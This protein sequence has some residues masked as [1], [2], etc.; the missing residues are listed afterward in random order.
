VEELLVSE[1]VEPVALDLVEE[2]VVSELVKKRVVSDSVEKPV[3]S[4][5]VEKATLSDSVEKPVVSGSVEKA[6]VS[7]SVEKASFSDSLEKPFVSGSVEKPVVSGSVEK[8]V[9]SELVEEPVVL[10]EELVVSESV[11]PVVL[12]LLEKPVVSELVEKPVVSDSVEKPV[13]LDLVEKPV[14]SDSV[15][16]PVVL[17]L[18]EKPAFSDS[19]E[20]PVVSDSVE[21]AAVS[22]SVEKPIVSGSVE[23]PVVSDSVEK[24]AISELAEELVSNLEEEPFVSDSVEKPTTVSV[25][26][27]TVSVEESIVSVEESI[28]S[29]LLEKCNIGVSDQEEPA[30]QIPSVSAVIKSFQEDLTEENKA[31]ELGKSALRNIVDLQNLVQDQTPRAV[32]K[33]SSSDSKCDPVIFSETASDPD[34]GNNRTVTRVEDSSLEEGAE[35]HSFS[36]DEANTSDVNVLIEPNFVPT[37]SY[38]PPTAKEEITNSHSS[39]A[40]EATVI[41]HCSSCPSAQ[42]YHQTTSKTSLEKRDVTDLKESKGHL[43]LTSVVS[44][45]LSELQ[46]NET[47]LTDSEGNVE[48]LTDQGLEDLLQQPEPAQTKT[49]ESFEAVPDLCANNIPHTES[50]K[51]KEK[52]ISSSSVHTIDTTDL[53]NSV[54]S[55][56]I[57]GTSFCDPSAQILEEELTRCDVEVENFTNEVRKSA[58]V[59][60]GPRAG[61]LEKVGKSG[62]DAQ[63][64]SSP[65]T[66]QTQQK[67]GDGT[68]TLT[69]FTCESSLPLC[70]ITETEEE[71]EKKEKAEFDVADLK[72]NTKE[73]QFPIAHTNAEELKEVRQKADS[74]L[75][76]ESDCV[77]LREV[78]IER[79]DLENPANDKCF[80]SD[81][82]GVNEEEFTRN[83]GQKVIHETD[84]GCKLDEVLQELSYLNK[85]IQSEGNEN[86]IGNFCSEPYADS[87]SNRSIDTAGS[88]LKT[89]I[90]EDNQQVSQRSI[91]NSVEEG[92]EE[93]VTFE[94]NLH[95][96][97]QS[98]QN[99]VTGEE[100]KQTSYPRKEVCS[101]T[102]GERKKTVASNKVNR[103][104][105]DTLAGVSNVSEGKTSQSKA[106]NLLLENYINSKGNQTAAESVNMEQ[107]NKKPS[108][109]VEYKG[110]LNM[111]QEKEKFSGQVKYKGRIN[112]EKDRVDCSS[113]TPIRSKD[114]KS[115]KYRRMNSDSVLL[116]EKS[117][118]SL[119]VLL[120]EINDLVRRTSSFECTDLDIRYKPVKDKATRRKDFRK[121]SAVKSHSDKEINIGSLVSTKDAVDDSNVLR[122]VEMYGDG[123]RTELKGNGDNRM[124]RSDAVA[125]G[126]GQMDILPSGSVLGG[127]RR[128]EMEG[129]QAGKPIQ[130]DFSTT[131]ECMVVG[132]SKIKKEIE[133]L[134]QES[135]FI[136][137]ENDNMDSKFL[138]VKDHL[139][140]VQAKPS[141]VLSSEKPN[142]HSKKG[143]KKRFPLRVLRRKTSLTNISLLDVN[144][145][146]TPSDDDREQTAVGGV[147]ST[148]TEGDDS[149]LSV[150][151][152]EREKRILFRTT[153]R[154]SKCR[155]PSEKSHGSN[156]D[157][158]SSLY[159]RRKS[160]QRH[161]S[162]NFSSFVKGHSSNE[163]SFDKGY[164]S[165][166]ESSYEKRSSSS[167]RPR[168]GNRNQ[169]LDSQTDLHP[170][171]R[172]SVMHQS[173]DSHLRDQ[174]SDMHQSIESSHLRNQ[175][176]DLH[177][178]NDS[179]HLRHQRKESRSD[180]HQSMDL[181]HLKQPQRRETSYDREKFVP[182]RSRTTNADKG[183][184]PDRDL[185]GETPPNPRDISHTHSKSSGKG[186]FPPP[187][188]IPTEGLSAFTKLMR[189]DRGMSTMSQKRSNAVRGIVTFL[190]IHQCKVI[191][192][193]S[194]KLQ[195]FL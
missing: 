66:I 22:D 55:A 173:M 31:V 80:L 139:S 83:S 17:D 5:S 86:I 190:L 46:R 193:N 38:H 7:V 186:S 150:S 187:G 92:K 3:V 67:R 94:N 174:S 108:K 153:M 183:T 172:R 131:S 36:T 88:Y 176:L 117:R 122:I 165:K 42:S 155:D 48:D 148:G 81:S 135:P 152:S 24:P 180:K 166:S 161:S 35:K 70:L 30:V 58:V 73:D 87:V 119:G 85:K 129:I 147:R 69:D 164:S 126:V 95:I 146:S 103:E 102:E 49:S 65:S 11:E 16:K 115:E 99:F 144:E 168:L 140:A 167:N 184:A 182:G 41:P 50:V 71:E 60:E 62:E 160:Y 37:E 121:Q 63:K 105:G 142:P 171:N 79:R 143:P 21:K 25:E 134:G 96:P 114:N 98:T 159:A 15:E 20:K 109:H 76:A 10:V 158:Q 179:P 19:V 56:S 195:P 27:P 61:A 45:S 51:E 2:P 39:G 93:T 177:Q 188:K 47:S 91:S 169:T 124:G 97:Q 156:T 106:S 127:K 34:F 163:F 29:H 138:P 18:V 53:R 23:K 192:I 170:R 26:E 82:S 132:G 57:K 90:F 9:I 32:N 14:V 128:K 175:R 151:E 72:Q 100:T 113:D 149:G 54:E 154:E 178:S 118:Q 64:I 194:F 84:F 104:K 74:A 110:M 185:L 13:V 33:D 137:K 111:E 59:D 6:T 191:H 130:S 40:P 123:K 12:D 78:D 101:E 136:E 77:L 120:E 43:N 157:N 162:G 125:A 28:V 52:Y 4:D 181:S 189:E 141:E 44:M 89:G 8:P 145:V 68:N 1:S 112:R 133:N 75:D 107:G 116:Y